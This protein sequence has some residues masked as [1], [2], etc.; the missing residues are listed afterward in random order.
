MWA[1]PADLL[2]YVQSFYSC[3]ADSDT[4]TLCRASSST[5]LPSW[6]TLVG[7]AR[8]ARRRCQSTNSSHNRPHR[9]LITSVAL[10]VVASFIVEYYGR[11]FEGQ[12]S[13]G[14]GTR[15]GWCLSRVIDA[16]TQ[17]GR[18]LAMWDPPPPRPHRI[19]L[20]GVQVH[21]SLR[22]SDP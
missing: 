15:A 5:I 13:G 12:L 17:R 7:T 9:Y 16:S 6:H 10:I 20:L 3:P 8:T 4:A 11:G 22:N 21:P 14:V 2:V 18:L 19:H 1:G